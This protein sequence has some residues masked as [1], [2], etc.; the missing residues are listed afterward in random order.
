MPITAANFRHACGAE[1]GVNA[2]GTN[3]LAGGGIRHVSTLGAATT[4]QTGGGKTRGSWSRRSWKFSPAASI[5]DTW[6]HTF[7]TNIGSPG[8]LVGRFYIMFDTLPNAIHTIV[9]EPNGLG[10]IRFEPTGNVLTAWAGSATTVRAGSYAVT[11]G[12]WYRI[13]FRITRGTTASTEWSVAVA[14]GTTVA[15]TTAT[16][17]GQAAAGIAGV[18]FGHNAA[19]QGASVAATATYYIDDMVFSGATTTNTDYPIGSGQGIALGPNADGTHS[20]TDGDF[21]WPDAASTHFVGDNSAWMFVKSV[22]GNG[23][24]STVDN[25]ISQ[26]VVRSAGYVELQFEDLPNTGVVNGL[27]V[28]SEHHGSTTGGHTQSLRMRL[29][30]GEQVLLGATDASDLTVSYNSAPWGVDFET[31]LPWT[32]ARID[33]VLARWGYSGD[34][35]GNPI[36]DGICLEIDYVPDS[37]L[38]GAVSP[39]TFS[40]VPQSLGR[41]IGDVAR[42]LTPIALTL[43]P[44]ALSKSIDPLNLQVNVVSDT[45]SLSWDVSPTAVDYSVFRRTPTTGVDFNPSA[46]TPVA[47]G[48]TT[49]S[50]DDVMLSPATYEWQVFGRVWTPAEIST[51]IAWYDASV[52][53][54]IV[55][56]DGVV[57]QWNDI[58]GNNRHMAQGNA[59][60]RPST[61]LA[62]INE[63]NVLSFTAANS[64]RLTTADL[65]SQG[66][67]ADPMTWLIV[68]KS[69]IT[70]QNRVLDVEV[71]P[72]QYFDTNN[73]YIMYSS[74]GIVGGPVGTTDVEQAVLVWNGP[75]S[76]LYINGR[77]VN[78][79]TTT[80]VGNLIYLHVGGRDAYFQGKVAEFIPLSGVISDANRVK[81]N[82]YV[83]EKWGTPWTPANTELAMWHDASFLWSITASS[84]Q[85][86]QWNDLSGKGRHQI[87]ATGTKQPI[88]G[89]R[90]VNGLNVLDYNGLQ[91]TVSA[92]FPQGPSHTVYAVARLDSS[93][94]ISPIVDTDSVTMYGWPRIAQR[95]WYVNE[96][97]GIGFSGGVDK[98]AISSGGANPTALHFM[99]FIFDSARQTITVEVDGVQKA[100]V[101]GTG[102]L[103]SGSAGIAVGSNSNV[104]GGM[105]GVMCETWMSPVAD[106]ASTRARARAYAQLKWGTP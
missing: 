82:N 40:L 95:R 39:V 94:G 17:T 12:V 70:T 43:L 7:K 11:T 15:Q 106:D 2:I 59:A 41:S 35:I 20:F 46:A 31:G 103:A 77:L 13:G 76:K 75:S 8:V 34:V 58:S 66:I 9:S 23:L 44:T 80:S 81:W 19:G 24:V 1:C 62:T 16:K 89:T 104:D 45:A 28:V 49:P 5:T 74:G 33:D 57:S 29:A 84:G 65:N 25:F 96:I 14:D 86:S 102:V 71:G 68:Y 78:S 54:S 69:D 6:A 92:A 27:V 3:L 85:V 10:G 83:R 53:S 32:K 67:A 98:H 100:Q 48:I 26:V 79:G 42:T 101:T 73:S 93:S 97:E 36:L 38:S 52:L 56:S 47:T 18:N 105:D 88:T 37:G 64:T 51:L 21:A 63:K 90:T 55:S 30:T 99:A 61:G 22:A 87:Q 91:G 50:F 72:R 60:Q 4:I